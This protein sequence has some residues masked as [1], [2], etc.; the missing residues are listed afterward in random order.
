MRRFTG[1]FVKS[2]KVIRNYTVQ[3]GVWNFLFAFHCTKTYVSILYCLRDIQRRIMKPLKQVY[4]DP[5]KPPLAEAQNVLVKQ[6]IR[7]VRLVSVPLPNFHQ[8]L[9]L[10]A[11]FH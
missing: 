3:Y 8:K 11:K 5:I 7:Y 1:N 10:Y 4:R 6:K 9:L 2:L